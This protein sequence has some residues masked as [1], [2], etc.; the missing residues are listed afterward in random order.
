MAV[1]LYA[2]ELTKLDYFGALILKKKFAHLLKVQ[3]WRMQ[4]WGVAMGSTTRKMNA[5][6]SH[7]IHDLV[8]NA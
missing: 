1:R 3:R 8:T 5:T 2:A 4:H 6:T 7:Q